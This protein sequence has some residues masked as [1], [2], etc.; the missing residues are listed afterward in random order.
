MR[1][2]AS[3]LDL[4]MQCLHWC[5]LEL[6]EDKPGAAAKFG[7]AFHE[8]A[9]SGDGVA[10]ELSVKLSASEHLE[11]DDTVR[12]WLQSSGPDPSATNEPAYA[13]SPEGKV[14][15][16][17][18]NI[19]REYDE[20][21]A[22]PH[23][24]CLSIDVVGKGYVKDYKTGRKYVSAEQ[25]W[26]L[27][28]ASAAT[29]ISRAGFEYVTRGTGVVHHD[30]AEHDPKKALEAIAA[31]ARDLRDGNSA[32]KFGDHCDKF[33]CPARAQCTA[34]KNKEKPMAY[35]PDRIQV[36]VQKRPLLLV[37]H[38]Q[39]GVGKS[40]FAACAPSPFFCDVERKASVL[41]VPRDEPGTWSELL[42][43]TE[44]A[45]SGEHSFKTFVLDTADAAELLAREHVC[46]TNG[47]ASIADFGFGKG[48]DKVAAEFKKLLDLTDK[49]RF[50][51]GMHV[52]MLAHT[53][54]RTFSNPDGED[55]DRYE[56]KMDKRVASLLR[57]R[58]DACMF[59]RYDIATKKDGEKVV[60]LSDGARVLQTMH[61]AAWDAKNTFGLPERLAFPPPPEAWNQFA[62]HYRAFYETKI[63]K[64]EEAAA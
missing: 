26:Q 31:R 56:L 24:V 64:K 42:E 36:G 44:W 55:Y 16:L 59:A 49:M 35:S 11:L 7:T 13:I 29:G 3:K 33:Y 52:I 57:E 12:G 39:E 9:A 41:G 46:K 28:A 58:S 54:I 17:G 2:T 6:P 25:S 43:M 63:A 53:Q 48:Q 61:S 30:W 50:Q 20:R 60:G 27:K 47:K 10:T 40:S 45:A 4:G 51:N 18:L 38:G 34:Y 19:N 22:G 32:P 23:D 1:L 15:L 62:Q 8:C 21:G 37:I 5:T 14:T